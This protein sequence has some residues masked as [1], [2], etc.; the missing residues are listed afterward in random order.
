MPIASVILIVLAMMMPPEVRIDIAGQTLYSYRIAWL[1]ASPWA[2]YRLLRGDF[3]WRLH[4]L[5]LVAGSGWI[6]FAMVMIYGIER[7]FPSGLGLALDLVAPYF[8]ARAAISNFDDL[9][10]MLIV[11]APVF[12]A[13]ALLLPIEAILQDRFIRNAAAAVF[14]RRGESEYG[15]S[16]AFLVASDT[17]FGLL[18]A[19]GPFSHPILAG[20]FFA[21]LMPLYHWSG[22][23]GWP[24]H[25]GLVASCFAVFTL[26]SAALL[27]IV[28]FATLASYDY[29]RRRVT[30]LTWPLFAVSASGILVILHLL[31]E[32]GLVS[33]LIRYT[34]TPQTGYYRL[35]VWQYGI[36]SV[37]SNPLFGIGF[38]RFDALAWMGDSI[39]AHWLNLAVRHG[40]PP[41]ILIL[42]V[43]LALFWGCAKAALRLPEP[44]S[45]TAIGLAVTL[46]IFVLMAFT[47]AYFGGML[48]WFTV[49]L[50]TASSIS[51]ES[52][53][54]T[55]RVTR[56]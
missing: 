27:A 54:R 3:N 53:P 50:G 7:G 36:A 48:I 46:L 31:S 39:D 30:F 26:S 28:I 17:R 37:E 11:L 2:L 45:S 40:L 38:E 9:R 14:G 5:L 32:N 49:I 4:D 23:R 18:R 34:L 51:A 47:V 8:I 44:D 24:K 25:L 29:L 42:A 1:L 19:M 13:F 10:R 41:A 43:T 12:F 15:M 6:A 55:A 33:V 52:Q 35:L 22:I 21:S 16:S 20:T 56:G